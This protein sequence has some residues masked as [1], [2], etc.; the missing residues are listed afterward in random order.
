MLGGLNFA[1]MRVLADFSYEKGSHHNPRTCFYGTNGN[2]DALAKSLFPWVETKLES[3]SAKKETAHDFLNM[4]LDFRW[5]ILQDAAILMNSGRKHCIFDNLFRHVFHSDEFNKLWEEIKLNCEKTTRVDSTSTEKTLR[6]LENTTG[7]ILSS[8]NEILSTFNETTN[9][10]QRTQVGLKNDIESVRKGVDVSQHFVTHISN[11]RP[12]QNVSPP[13]LRN[14]RPPKA[15]MNRHSFHQ[16]SS[17]LLMNSN[18]P[19]PST[20]LRS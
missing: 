3:Y 19:L 20:I 5:L 4:L 16:K 12:L 2:F 14:S 7:T 13:Y 10:L 18:L 6:K 1:S 9:Q 8:T 15:T 11:C 17:T